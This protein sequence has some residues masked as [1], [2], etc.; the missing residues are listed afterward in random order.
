MKIGFAMRRPLKWIEGGRV[1]LPVDFGEFTVSTTKSWERRPA[2]FEYK[3][4]FSYKEAKALLKQGFL[5]Y[6][7]SES[8]FDT[9][10]ILERNSTFNALIEE[11]RCKYSIPNDLAYPEHRELER[12]RSKEWK[13][14]IISEGFRFSSEYKMP[15]LLNKGSIYQLLFTSTLEYFED[16]L[17]MICLGDSRASGASVPICL[18]SRDITISQLHQFIDSH[19]GEIRR[20][21]KHLRRHPLV[22]ARELKRNLRIYDLKKTNPLLSWGKLTDVIS[23]EF[24]SDQNA[25]EA[26]IR[27]AYLRVEKLI[28]SY[29]SKRKKPLRLTPKTFL[30]DKWED[31]V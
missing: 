15:F 21:I 13:K 4:V 20:A 1:Q 31:E 3:R 28:E 30:A 19:Q 2:E 12:S 17:A 24:P 5:D 16:D 23:Q 26:N 6:G 22:H 29:F 18:L 9:L 25:N 27:M 14:N 8:L 10:S 11:L 7:I